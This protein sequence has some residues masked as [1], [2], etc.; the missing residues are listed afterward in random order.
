MFINMLKGTRLIELLPTSDWFDHLLRWP[1]QEKGL[2]NKSLSS[3]S[4]TVYP[5]RKKSTERR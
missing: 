3:F 2:K 5:W 1:Q 4:G